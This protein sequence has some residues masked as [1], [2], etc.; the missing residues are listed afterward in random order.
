[1]TAPNI[2]TS[3]EINVL[4]GNQT[5]NVITGNLAMGSGNKIKGDFSNAVLTS[6]TVLQSSTLN[7]PTKVIAIPNGAATDTS[8]S[9][10]NT[11]DFSNSNLG[12]SLS[13]TRAIVNSTA[14]SGGTTQPL[15]F[16]VGDTYTER[17]YIDKL[18]NVVVGT[19]NQ[20]PL[21]TTAT[22]GF[23]YIPKCTGTPTGTPTAMSGS[24]PLVIDST[25]SKMYFYNGTSWIAVN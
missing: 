19:V 13:A 5:D 9:L 25:N 18:G 1:M 6:R 10:D 24:L 20:T 11:S 17:L 15:V 14:R 22:D 23:F 7:G 8:W 2:M 12:V 4:A 3:G 16:A 21:A